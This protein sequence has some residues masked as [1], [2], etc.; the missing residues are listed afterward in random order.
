[1]D[2]TC[3]GAQVRKEN[4]LEDDPPGGGASHGRAT[5]KAAVIGAVER[6]G[7]GPCGQNLSGKGVLRLFRDAVSPDRTLLITDDDAAYGK[8]T[9][10]DYRHAVINHSVAYVDGPAHTN[11]IEGCWAY[12]WLRGIG[13][14]TIAM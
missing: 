1:M 12:L 13:S 5:G 8:A 11:T 2:E 10:E 14:T 6:G 4:G 9:R 7:G 3:V